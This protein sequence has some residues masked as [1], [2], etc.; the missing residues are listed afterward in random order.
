MKFHGQWTY[1]YYYNTPK[2]NSDKI[3]KPMDIVFLKKIQLLLSLNSVFASVDSIKSC[4][5]SQ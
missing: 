2:Q 4:I 3:Y 5:M 1:Q